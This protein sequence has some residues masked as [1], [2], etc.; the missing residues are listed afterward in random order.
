MPADI[1]L[2]LS[3]YLSNRSPVK[4]DLDICLRLFR[5]LKNSDST[6]SI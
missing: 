1:D 3:F 6:H 5:K 4:C 2:D